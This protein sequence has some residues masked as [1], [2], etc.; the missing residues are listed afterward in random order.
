MPMNRK[1]PNNLKFM[2]RVQNKPVITENIMKK[3]SMTNWDDLKGWKSNEVN[4]ILKSRIR[5]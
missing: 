4:K 2:D 3:I 5:T 1:C